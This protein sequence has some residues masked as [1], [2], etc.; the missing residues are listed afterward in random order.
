MAARAMW[1]GVIT[2]EGIEVPVKLYSAI[3]DRSI[4]FRFLHRK[5]RTPVKQALVDGNDNVVPFPETRRMYRTG[6][7]EEVLISPDELEAIKPEPSRDIEVLSFLPREAIDHRWYDRPY[8]LGPD[9]SEKAYSAL[10]RA[11]QETEREGLA[12]WVMR[13]K[14]YYGAL[15]LYEG[16]PMLMSLRYQ[17]EVIPAS[18]L[19]PPRGKPLERKELAMARQLIDM[20]KA[21]FEPEAYQDEYRE[22]VMEMIDRKRKGGT[23]KR[24]APARKKPSDNI[25]EALEASLKGARDGRKKAPPKKGK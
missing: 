23:V 21:D 15:R 25:A 3:E 18:E 22:R 10:T 8:Y 4:R 17:E 7:G 19:E 11:L 6:E 1:K 9:G 5:D 20:L 24:A 13:N 2:F 12:H 16:Y 14:E